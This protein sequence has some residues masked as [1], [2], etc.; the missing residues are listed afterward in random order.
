MVILHNCEFDRS[1]TKVDE[2]LNTL[3]ASFDSETIDTLPLMESKV[4][5]ETVLL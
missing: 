3:N 4:Y 2:Y 1:I 5:I